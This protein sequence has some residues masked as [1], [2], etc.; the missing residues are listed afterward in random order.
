M[1]TDELPFI[2]PGLVDELIELRATLKPL[3]DKQTELE[4]KLKAHPEG[5][6]EGTFGYVLVNPEIIRKVTNWKKIAI[7]LGATK[8]R[9]AK[10][11]KEGKPYV[12]LNVN[13]HKKAA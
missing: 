6:Y 3:L 4:G 10:N 7:D 1:K 12:R 9:I 5:K 13:V 2:T 11:T 8:L